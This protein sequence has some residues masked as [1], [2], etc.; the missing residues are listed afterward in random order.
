M[1]IGL[2]F[3]IVPPTVRDE[4]LGQVLA[5]SFSPALRSW[6]VSLLSLK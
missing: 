5:D 1:E 3:G 4:K 2:Q 6:Q